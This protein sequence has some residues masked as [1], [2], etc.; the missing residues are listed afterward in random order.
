MSAAINLS[1]EWDATYDY[2]S[3]SADWWSK[4]EAGLDQM[5]E[6]KAEH[7]VF[8]LQNRKGG[9]VAAV[10]RYSKILDGTE[11]AGFTTK[12]VLEASGLDYYEVMRG[13]LNGVVSL[14]N[15]TEEMIEIARGW[16]GR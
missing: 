15:E 2:A 8:C 3:R 10:N 16:H 12:A 11:P 1:H 13:R 9:L 5:S 6:K 4:L 14:L 7:M